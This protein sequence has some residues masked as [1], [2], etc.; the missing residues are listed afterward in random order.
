MLAEQRRIAGE[1]GGRPDLVRAK[2]HMPEPE[3]LRLYREALCVVVPSRDEGFSLPVVEAMA[4]GVPVLASRIPAHEE[5]LGDPSALFAPDDDEALARPAGPGRRSRLAVA[6]GRGE[7]GSLAAL[8]GRGGGGAVLVRDRGPDRG[9]EA[10]DPAARRPARGEAAAGRALAPA[11]GALGHRGLHGE[12]VRGAGAARRPPPLHRDPWRVPAPRRRVCRAPL[13]PALPRHG[14]RPRGRRDGQ[15]RSPSGQPARPAALRRRRDLPR[16]AAA[17]P[18]LASPRA[19]AGGAPRGGGAGPRPRAG[20]AG[21]LALG[22]AAAGR[23]AVRGACRG[24]RSR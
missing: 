9:G 17:R 7:R 15:L 4:S 3:L 16:W 10:P 13:R 20:R 22:A 5:L 18:L 14:L 21:V 11:A 6:P 24:R 12:H 8:P 19:G 23:A 2:A 1:M